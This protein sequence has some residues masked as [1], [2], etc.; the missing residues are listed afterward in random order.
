LLEA[1]KKRFKISSKVRHGEAASIP[2][3]AKE[4]I[5]GLQTVAGEYQEED[6]YN[7]DESALF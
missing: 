6:I 7:I 4:E 5:K 2:Q 3:S 1:F